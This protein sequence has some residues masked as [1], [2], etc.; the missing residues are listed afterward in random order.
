MRLSLVV[1]TVAAFVVGTTA[2]AEPATQPPT[3]QVYITV[4]GLG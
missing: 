2:R 4:S 3:E 1:L